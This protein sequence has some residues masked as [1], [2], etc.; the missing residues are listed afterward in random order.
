MKKYLVK[1]L[2]RIISGNLRH[3]LFQLIGLNNYISLIL[4]AVDHRGNKRAAKNVLCIERRLFEKDVEELSNRVRKYGWIWLRKNQITVYQTPVLPKTHLK[5]G[6]YLNK[7]QEAPEKWDECIKRS[8]LLIKRFQKEKNVC[9]LMLANLDYYQ[10]YTLRVACIELGIPVLV[11][12]KEYPYN[13]TALADFEINYYRKLNIKPNADAIMVFGKRM[14]NAY[15]KLENFDQKK[16]FVT[17]APRIDRWRSIENTSQSSNEG[18]VIISFMF[19]LSNKHFLDLL[20]KVSAYFKNENLGKITVKSREEADDKIIKEFCKKENLKNVEVICNIP[21]Y[22][23]VSQSKA[24]IAHNSLATVESMLSIK[25]ILLPD[26]LIENDEGKLFN[27]E[28]PLCKK[29]I[30]LCEREQDLFDN[31]SRIFENK[32]ANVSEESFKARKE[33]ISRFWEYD[34]NETACSKVQK[35]I[36]NFVEKIPN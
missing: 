3:L 11:L 29:A 32:T 7:I 34:D 36:D 8:K 10:D 31:I 23:L 18:L 27:P 24:V 4:K 17:G 16:I 5:Q 35:V 14:K 2:S 21:I 28:D 12:Q 15:A 30:N 25:P 6:E 20:L 13:D 19:R 1:F 22:D 33:F 26:W 9:A